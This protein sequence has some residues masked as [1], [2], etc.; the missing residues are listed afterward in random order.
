M[1][2]TDR[3]LADLKHFLI[4]QIRH[5]RAHV[6]VPPDDVHAAGQRPQVVVHGLAAHVA[7]AQHVLHL[8]RYEQVTEG[9]GYAVTAMGDVQIT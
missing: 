7:R 8:A 2:Q 3:E 5:S 6:H 1:C 9:V 4:W